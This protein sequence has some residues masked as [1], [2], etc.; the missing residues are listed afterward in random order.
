MTNQQRD[1]IR[2]GA[3]RLYD[4]TRR[5]LLRLIPL[6]SALQVILSIALPP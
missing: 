2:R 1:E 6:R 4:L 3:E 5:F